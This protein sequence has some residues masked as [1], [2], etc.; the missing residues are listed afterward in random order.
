M[1]GSSRHVVLSDNYKDKER[2]ATAI[3][4]D[5]RT[6]CNAIRDAKLRYIKTKLRARSKKQAEDLSVF[7]ALSDYCS[8]RDIQDAYGYEVITEAEMDRLN[9]LWDMREQHAKNSGQ[10]N[11]RV[12]ELLNR[13]ILRCGDEY[14]ESL[15]EFAVM[16][17]QLKADLERIECE[18]RDND[19]MRHHT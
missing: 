17:K 7:D 12:T 15:E 4:K 11:D 1:I 5:I 8:K 9:H 19:Y 3:R 16:E 13:A 14:E 10:F 2:E 18:N 6:A